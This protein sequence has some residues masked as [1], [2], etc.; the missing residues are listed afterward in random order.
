MKDK[1]TDTSW[2]TRDGKAGY[3]KGHPNYRVQPQTLLDKLKS[4]IKR[5]HKK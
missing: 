4:I 2:L 5:K 3:G 1:P